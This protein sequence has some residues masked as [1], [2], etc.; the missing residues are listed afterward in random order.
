MLALLLIF[1]MLPST[2]GILQRMTHTGPDLSNNEDIVAS[3]PEKR[4]N[5]ADMEDRH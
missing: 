4:T 1:L 5:E 3:I 2:K